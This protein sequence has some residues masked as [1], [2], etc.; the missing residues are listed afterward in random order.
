MKHVTAVRAHNG[1]F[2]PFLGLAAPRLTWNTSTAR[3]CSQL[4]TSAVPETRD[5]SFHVKHGASLTLRGHQNRDPDAPRSDRQRLSSSRRT[6][7]PQRVG[8]ARR[9]LTP[10]YQVCLVSRETARSDQSTSEPIVASTCI[11]IDPAVGSEAAPN[12]HRLGVALHRTAL[13]ACGAAERRPLT[14]RSHDLGG[15]VAGNQ[16]G[17]DP[18]GRTAISSVRFT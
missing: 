18:D 4:G 13:P 6:P 5:A 3:A 1:G 16:I 9:P 10:S 7:S 8:T 17:H 15:E 2:P 12:S 14:G 11:G